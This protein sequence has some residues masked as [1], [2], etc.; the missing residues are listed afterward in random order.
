MTAAI[1]ELGVV[2]EQSNRQL[3]HRVE[4]LAARRAGEVRRAER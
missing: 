3:Q 4:R 2:L 1:R